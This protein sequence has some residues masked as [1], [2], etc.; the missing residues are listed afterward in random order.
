MENLGGFTSFREI[1]K[2]EISLF[3]KAM[4]GLVGVRYTPLA[5]ATQV[6][7]GIN[8]SYLCDSMVVVPGAVNYNALVIIHKAMDGKTSIMEIKKVKII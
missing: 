5:V 6:V 8:Y 3:E 4:N 1:T 7:N 2:E